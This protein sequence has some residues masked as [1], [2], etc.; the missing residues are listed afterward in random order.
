MFASCSSCRASR[1]MKL[2]GQLSRH[3][4]HPVRLNT[5]KVAA[6]V[7]TSSVRPVTSARCPRS[8]LLQCSHDRLYSITFIGAAEL[9]DAG[10]NAEPVIGSAF[11]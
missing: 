6:A 5:P 10:G 8:R 4:A 2:L 11:A 7:R 9:E 3:V 1:P